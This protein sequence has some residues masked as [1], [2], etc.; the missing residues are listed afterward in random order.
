MNVDAE[1]LKTLDQMPDILKQE[2][3][4]YAK[5]LVDNYSQ[6]VSPESPP[7]KKRRSGILQGTFVLP[8]PENFDEPLEDFQE[9]ME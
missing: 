2:L 8:L 6:A 9:Y 7:Q 4:H 5:Y 3:L 1:I